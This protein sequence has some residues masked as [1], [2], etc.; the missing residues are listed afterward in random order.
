VTLGASAVKLFER[1]FG[2]EP[3]IVVRSPGRVNIIGDHTDY[4][5]GFVLPMAIDKA[6]WIAV[7]PR[8]DETV[9]VYA[10]RLDEWD[11]FLVRSPLCHEGWRAYI[12]GVAHE[13]TSEGHCLS[14]WD[15]AIVSDL[16]I[17]AGLSS[18]AAL[19]MAA[20]RCFS[21]VSGVQW[22]PV[23]MA[24]ISQRAENDW[25]GVQCGIMDQLASGTGEAGH[26]MLID[27]RSL[28]SRPVRIP[29]G[30]S[31]NILDTGTRRDLVDSEY[32]ERKASC[33]TACTVLKVHALR[34][35]D[36]GGL[37]SAREQMD[38]TTFRCAR[39]V[40]RENDAVLRVAEAF[41]RG[42]AA[43]AG[44][45]MNRSHESLRSDFEV[46]TPAL[47]AMVAAATSTTGCYG[48][49]MTGAGFGGAVV[50]LV[51]DSAADM[52]AEV[53]LRKYTELVGPFGT[54]IKVRAMPGTSLE[55]IPKK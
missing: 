5:E 10:S 44:E 19:E 23:A 35:V 51:D 31:L 45:L 37:E 17:G 49:R 36:L 54:A 32:N 13:L 48:A 28:A 16:P 33:E 53:A 14:G 1:C 12:Q 42:D 24:L 4:N 38:D 43:T 2:T 27:C 39:H 8:R 22:D 6:V 50:A 47:D 20:A 15:G 21:E 9:R 46:S 52:F 3:T 25:V 55:S 11:R 30:V 18:S 26:A 7:A 41:E 40:I 29:D 34:D